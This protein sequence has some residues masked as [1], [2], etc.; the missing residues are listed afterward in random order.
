MFQYSTPQT[1][2]TQVLPKPSSAICGTF[3]V[4]NCISAIR[5]R[6]VDLKCR[7]KYFALLF[8]SLSILFVVSYVCILTPT[9]L[10][11]ENLSLRGNTVKR[12]RQDTRPHG[13]ELT[14]DHLVDQ[15]VSGVLSRLKNRTKLDQSGKYLVIE[16]LLTSHNLTSEKKHDVTLASQCTSNHL[17]YVAELSKQWQGPV[18][19]AVFTY[20]D[21][22]HFAIASILH[23][24]LCFASVAEHVTFHLAFPADRKPDTTMK[25]PQFE[26]ILCS[27]P[28]P[29]ERKGRNAPQKNFVIGS[30]IEY[31]V[32]L[33]R[34]V[35]LRS[36]ST[37]YVL[38]TDVDMTPSDNLRTSFV[39]HIAATSN[40]MS[41]NST[42]LAYVVP[43][44][45]YSGR[46]TA[47][48]LNKSTVLEMWR[49][50]TIRPFS[51]NISSHCHAPTNYPRWRALPA[52]DD[53]MAVAYGVKFQ[54]KYE[55]YYIAPS[56]LPLYDER[57]VQ[58]GRDRQSQVCE[59]HVAGYQL[60]VLNDAFLVHD[61]FKNSSQHHATW[62]QEL[63]KNDIKYRQFQRDLKTKY[64]GV[65]RYCNWRNV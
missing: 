39:R 4:R 36:V 58:W 57:F 24:R 64:P 42:K 32:N 45:E 62:Q 63:Q 52:S 14:V 27:N 44:F 56:S 49:M 2:N 29:A 18:S 5:M 34:N 25:L 17:H 35:A 23:L 8:S 65:K 21:D 22:F 53:K 6:A 54:P 60:V 47:I 55:P 40:M 28:P 1:G 46:V 10:T 11:L 13:R 41:H 38:Y 48:P 20:D 26:N 37:T 12:L 7:M 19:I 43:A 33:L 51:Q 15:L 50:H 31:P 3:I 61:G 9:R 30:G 59:M 16:D